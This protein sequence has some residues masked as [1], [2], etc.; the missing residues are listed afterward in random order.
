MYILI[1]TYHFQWLSIGTGYGDME[2]KIIK[3]LPDMKIDKMECFEPGNEQFKHLKNLHFGF[4]NKTIMHNEA[5]DENTEL[6]NLSENEYTSLN[7]S[8]NFHCRWLSRRS[9]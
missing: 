3:L 2:Q 5:F 7:L 8:D 1:N 9:P 4:A 6:G